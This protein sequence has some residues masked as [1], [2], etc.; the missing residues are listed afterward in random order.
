MGAEQLG[1]ECL[2]RLF[3]LTKRHSCDLLGASPG[4]TT[5]LIDTIGPAWP[6][7]TFSAEA[8]ISYFFHGH[9]DCGWCQELES[10]PLCYWQGPSGA[11][12]HRLL[13]RSAAYGRDR[14]CGPAR[15]DGVYEVRKAEGTVMENIV[16]NLIDKYTANSWPYDCAAFPGFLRLLT[17]DARSR[18]H[19]PPLEREVQ[20]SPV[21]FR[22]TGYV[23]RRRGASRLTRQRSRLM[24]RTE[25]TSG[26]TR[27]RRS[28]GGW[29]W[30]GE[31]TS[32]FPRPKSSPRLP[33]S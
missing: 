12:Q 21:D 6:L 29:A 20:L 18:R 4:R 14:I 3:Y 10:Q 27:I 26:R 19:R 33:P 31:P 24:P 1:H 30:R 5:A 23:L 11:V 28:P 17:G 2:A 15:N 32:R 7:A 25:T 16:V 8:G 22:D 9:N 13:T